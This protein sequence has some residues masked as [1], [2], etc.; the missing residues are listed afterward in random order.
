ASAGRFLYARIESF[1]EDLLVRAGKE[2]KTEYCYHV[3]QY[4]RRCEIIDHLD[5]LVAIELSD[6]I[7]SRIDQL[8]LEIEK[9][10]GNSISCTSGYGIRVNLFFCSYVDLAWELIRLTGNEEH[11]AELAKRLVHTAVNDRT[12]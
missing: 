7:R 1:A 2:L 3:G 9:E 10:N 12:E 5:I 6:E 11:V 8:D 4:R